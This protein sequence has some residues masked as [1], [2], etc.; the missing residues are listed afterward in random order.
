M[1]QTNWQP[2]AQRAIDYM[3]PY[4]S[5]IILGLES[6]QRQLGRPIERKQFINAK[7]V[8]AVLKATFEHDAT[9]QGRTLLEAFI[10]EPN[11]YRDQLIALV[12]SRAVATPDDFGRKLMAI[13]N[14]LYE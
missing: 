8:Y 10:R 12:V 5:V 4:A 2:I 1:E 9:D 14:R 13:T 6:A 11:R 3:A 7:S